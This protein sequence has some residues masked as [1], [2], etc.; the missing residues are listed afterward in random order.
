MAFFPECF[1][2][3]GR[4]RDETISLAIE[5]D[6]QYINQFREVA[7]EHRIW[8]SLGGF[9]NK[10]SFIVKNQPPCIHMCGGR[11][12]AVRKI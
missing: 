7:R 10:V 1:D 6:G 2:Y 11:G 4:N 12:A 8:L 9:H 3:I 5:E